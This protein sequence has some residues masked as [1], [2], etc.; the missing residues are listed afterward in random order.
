MD[1]NLHK[2]REIVKDREAWRV[3][4]HGVRQRVGHDLATEQQ[5]THV[6]ILYL[7]SLNSHL[8]VITITLQ[9]IIPQS[10]CLSF[11]SSYSPCKTTNLEEIQLCQLHAYIEATENKQRNRQ[12]C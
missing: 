12:P 9:Y 1:M 2:L 6:S 7:S 3:A 8:P 5:Q 10:F 4:V 11:G